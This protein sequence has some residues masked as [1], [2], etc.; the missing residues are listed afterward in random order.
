MRRVVVLLVLPLLLFASFGVPLGADC[1]G[2]AC[3]RKAGCPM[4]AKG[5]CDMAGGHMHCAGMADGQ[6]CMMD[7]HCNGRSD[8]AGLFVLLNQPVLL[9]HTT[10]PALPA[11]ADRVAPAAA[12]VFP[13]AEPFA[14][15]QPPRS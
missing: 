9:A 3:C 2:A 6:H 12:L 10:V 14:P 15:W 1:V 13:T 4:C 11:L 5:H 8:L 7:G